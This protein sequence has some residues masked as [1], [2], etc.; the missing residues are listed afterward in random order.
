VEIFF[1]PLL[2]LTLFLALSH[3]AAELLDRPS[4][5]LTLGV[6]AGLAAQMKYVVVFD[7]AA[8]FLFLFPSLWQQGGRERP[9][10]LLRFLALAA[11][12]AATPL[13]IVV[14][15]LVL[16]G[17]FAD[18]FDANFAANA[19][20]VSEVRTD[21]GTLGSMIQMRVREN[22]PLWLTLVLAPAY[23]VFF[24]ELDRGTRRGLA[25]GLLWAAFAFLGMC[26][27]RRP[28]PHYLLA[29]TPALCLL[30]A[31]VVC[32]AVKCEGAADPPTRAALLLVLVL[33][34]SLLR[35]AEDPIS[36]A[37]RTLYHRY[38]LRDVFWGDRPSLLADY[39]RSRVGPDDYLYVA[40]YHPILYYLLPVRVPT[41]FPLPAHLADE[42]GKD[43]TGID[44][45]E[46]VQ[47]IFAK[48]PR[49]VV[50]VLDRPT[51]FYKM[52]HEELAR[53]YRLENTIQ[54]VKVYRRL[55]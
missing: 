43:L 11:A 27:M 16:T 49:Y 35:A 19:R 44:P 28:F 9:A 22:F 15:S 20:Y 47:A 38:V 17:H 52:V 30:C 32:S 34:G 8:F 42:H 13:A 53:S 4:L 36:L 55:E 29:L 37:A 25:V 48:Q 41:R 10:H 31:L 7:L 1:T 3:D 5:A 14:A 40:D 2:L 24:R 54:G 12:G 23:L 45:E 51:A 6:L 26:A 39:L 50:K 33:L 46:E 18:Y 21:L